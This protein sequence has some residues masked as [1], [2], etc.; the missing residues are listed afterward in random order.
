LLKYLVYFNDYT[1]RFHD[2][3]FHCCHEVEMLHANTDLFNNM[4]SQK[5]LR[6]FL[7]VNV[8]V[9]FAASCNVSSV[10]GAILTYLFIEV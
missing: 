6:I 9:T 1:L 2:E 8:I 3:V 4:D 10:N 5:Y 7:I